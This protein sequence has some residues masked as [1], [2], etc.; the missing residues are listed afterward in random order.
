MPCSCT[1][2]LGAGLRL[3]R[4]HL[5]E[6]RLTTSSRR[7]SPKPSI[8]SASL[9]SRSVP[10]RDELTSFSAARHSAPTEVSKFD[11]TR[12]AH[13]RRNRRNDGIDTFRV[14]Q[15]RSPRAARRASFPR[16]T[17]SAIAS[18]ELLGATGA[19]AVSL[20]IPITDV[21]SLR[22]QPSRPHRRGRQNRHS[23]APGFVAPTG[24]TRYRTPR[25]AEPA[26][27]VMV[28]TA[29]PNSPLA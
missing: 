15:K 22:Q 11:I 10:N 13:F 28:P 25:L 17:T 16:T 26:A 29:N 18:P 24:P 23:A 7:A 9:R 2:A 6:L 27:G 12:Q 21:V 14:R 4:R 5:R 3:R 8:S 1:C 19:R 20:T